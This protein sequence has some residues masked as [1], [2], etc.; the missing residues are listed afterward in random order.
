MEQL[1][2]R[3]NPWW[4]NKNFHHQSIER[5]LLIEKTENVVNQSLIAVI[6]GLRRIGKTTLMKQ[7]IYKLITQKQIE[8]KYIFFVSLDNYLL[9]DQSLL[10]IVE[11]YFKIHGLSYS[12]KVYLFFDEITYKEDYEVQLKNLIDSYHVQIVISS[13]S[14]S[15]LRNRKAHLTGRTS[16]VEILPLDFEEYLQ[17]K[18]IKIKTSDSHLFEKYF[19]DFLVTGGIPAFVLNN[20]IEFIQNLVDDIIYKDIAVLH[21]INKTQVLKDYFLLLMERS[22]KQLSINKIA[23][24]LKISPDTSSRYLELFAET[25]LISMVTRYGKTNEQVLAP[26]KIYAAD[27]GIRCFFTGARDFGSLFENYV[28]LKLKHLNPKY[29]Y[30]DSTEID[31]LTESKLMIEVK[32]H[33]E[34]L[35]EKQQ[36]LFDNFEKCKQKTIVRNFN[37]LNKPKLFIGNKV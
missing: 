5:P 14:S 3:Y 26:K 21:H 28:F 18:N 13:S 11:E 9:K 4:E 1:F 12:E 10:A 19:M 35:S 37:D 31:F 34:S 8:Q 22:G 29:V 30:Q 36:K 23:T 32:F 7:I 25:F 24:I 17:F 15:M 2:Y 33:N 16:T 20:Q 27:L 6:S